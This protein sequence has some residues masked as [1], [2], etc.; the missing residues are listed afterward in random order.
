MVGVRRFN[1]KIE[2][3]PDNLSFI[4]T[5]LSFVFGIDSALQ[6]RIFELRACLDLNAAEKKSATLVT[7]QPLGGCGLRVEGI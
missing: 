7:P 1:E 5:T 4:D 3:N 6:Q 2:N